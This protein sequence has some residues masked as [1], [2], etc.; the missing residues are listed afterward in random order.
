MLVGVMMHT[1]SIPVGAAPGKSDFADQSVCLSPLL[2]RRLKKEIHR[3]TRALPT[4]VADFASLGLRHP[5]EES[6]RGRLFET[7]RDLLGGHAIGKLHW[8]RNPRRASLEM[9]LPRS[10]V[11]TQR[12]L[13]RF[14]A[15]PVVAIEKFA[16]VITG[17]SLRRSRRSHPRRL[18][19]LSRRGGACRA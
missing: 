14:V 19:S 16:G 8:S 5:V 11:R 12:Q 7:E 9:S 1:R 4:A 10:R 6:L 15:R 18:R 3:G 17:S 2:A 13:L